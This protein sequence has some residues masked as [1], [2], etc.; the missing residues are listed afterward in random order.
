MNPHQGDEQKAE[1]RSLLFGA[2][3][4]W[5]DFRC[6]HPD[7]ISRSENLVNTVKLAF[8]PREVVE[9]VDKILFHIARLC[10][11]EFSEILLL[12]GNGY[13]IGAEKLLRGLYERAVTATYLHEHPEEA[14]N[15]LHFYSI[16]NYKLM[17][18][19]EE[20]LAKDAFPI[21]QRQQIVKEYDEVKSKFMVTACSRCGTQRLNHTWSKLDIVSMAK[22]SEALAQLLVPAYYAGLRETHSTMGAIFSRLSA[23]EAAA[24]E[25]LIFAGS[26]QPERADQAL[27]TAHKI[28]LI[29]LELHKNHFHI[30]SLNAHLQS[31]FADFFVIWGDNSPE[32][33]DC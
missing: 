18:A 6:R 25:G 16:S 32:K 5:E 23:D 31:C 9:L 20:T 28:L 24:D 30:D 26:P 10:A 22:K 4:Q 7:F 19:V 1:G 3:R 11:E 21:D 29:V 14:E 15:Y 33:V 12:C 13:G 8:Q 27:L 2:P 17:I